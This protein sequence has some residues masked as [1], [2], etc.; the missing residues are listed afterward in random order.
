M[1]NHII[2]LLSSLQSKLR[3]QASQKR[4]TSQGSN[5]WDDTFFQVMGEERTSRVRTYGLGPTHS[6]VWGPLPTRGQLMKMTSE[7]KRSADKEVSKVLLKME[8]MEQKYAQ[9]EAHI[10]RMTSNMQKLLDK[11]GETSKNLEVTYSY[12]WINCKCIP[13]NVAFNT[14]LFLIGS[15]YL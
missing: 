10:S 4:K 12:T 9:M 13:L 8:A 11:I 5:D 3:Q 1:I 6:D 7:A 14:C 15:W 2:W